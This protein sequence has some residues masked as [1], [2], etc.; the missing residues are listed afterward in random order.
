M[1]GVR[2]EVADAATIVNDACDELQVQ[3]TGPSQQLTALSMSAEPDLAVV[4]SAIDHDALQEQRGPIDDIG[5]FE[6]ILAD[7][8]K[9]KIQV[10]KLVR[11]CVDGLGIKEV[12][13]LVESAPRPL[14]SHVSQ[15]RAE[16][17]K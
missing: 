7:P 13:E 2:W 8:G 16:G 14:L 12:K 17:V 10:I 9:R 3:M 6:V 1:H 4:I 15:A 11:V 5:N